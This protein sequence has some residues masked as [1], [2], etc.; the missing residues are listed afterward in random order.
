MII[1]KDVV[2]SAF[3]KLKCSK[4]LLKAIVFILIAIILIG[5]CVVFAGTK[6]TYNIKIGGKVLAST[7]GLDVYEE[8]MNKAQAA[9][10]KSD[11]LIAEADVEKV[12]SVNAKTSS[13]DEVAEIILENSPSV[14]NGYSVAA[15]GKVIAYVENTDGIEEALS[16]RLSSFDIEGTESS[17]SYSSEITYTETYF[18]K[19]QLTKA[20]ELTACV[21]GL[22]VVTVASTSEEYVIKYE[23]VTKKDSTK[24]AGTETVLTAGVNGSGKHV[25]KTTYVNGKISGDPIVDDQIISK[26][27]DKVVLVGTKNV[28]YTS[29][30]QNASS[31][32]F[33]WP[34]ATRGRIS[35]Y[36]GDGRG[37]K[38]VDICVPIGT[39]VLAVKS[40]VVVESRYTSDYGYHITIDHGNGIK[41][42]YAH[43]SKLL[44][45]VGDRV[46]K[47]QLIA[48]SGNTGYSTGPHLH[49]EVH[50]N[51]TRV[52]PANFIGL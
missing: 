24:N 1:I 47:G 6:V 17:S 52:N 35:S 11:L 13:S 41:T 39:S 15:D 26:P 12:V 10:P 50:I 40:G 28:Y 5:G 19:E 37:H 36:W 32:G 25:T 38:G 44:V 31:Y 43:N 18:H 16:K 45:S 48:Q 7:A 34:L 14:L 49:F 4:Q 3:A 42:R 22:D 51:G 46:E 33:G 21:S 8:A 2:I 9:L 23:T 29:A 27:T 30:P 20:S